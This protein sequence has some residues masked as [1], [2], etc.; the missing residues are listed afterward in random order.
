MTKDQLRAECQ[1]RMHT[2]S[3]VPLLTL[4]ALDQD[5]VEGDLLA[6]FANCLKADSLKSVTAYKLYAY[7]GEDARALLQVY[8]ADVEWL[9][10]HARSL[11]QLDN[12]LR[13]LRAT[14]PWRAA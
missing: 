7:M 6:A 14:L 10:Q 4:S 8:A 11:K 13:V 9:S 1:L 2:T 5:N 12:A 3:A